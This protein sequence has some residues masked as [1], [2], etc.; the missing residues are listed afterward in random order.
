MASARYRG[1][2]RV[3]RLPANGILLTGA[4]L[5]FVIVLWSTSPKTDL[6]MRVYVPVVA[7]TVACALGIICT[8][9]VAAFLAR[10]P[11]LATRLGYVGS[12]SLFVP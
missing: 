12:M 1:S 9:H 8:L 6:N 5:A 10:V 3:K 4:A 2:E 11:V 7:T